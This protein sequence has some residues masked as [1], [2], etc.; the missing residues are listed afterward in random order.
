MK[1]FKLFLLI[2]VGLVIL[3][4]VKPDIIGYVGPSRS[5]I[6]NIQISEF[7]QVLKAFAADTGRFPTSSEGLDALLNDPCNLKGWHGPYLKKDIPQDPWGR[8]YGYCCPGI[9]NPAHY[10]LWSN[11]PDGIEGTGDDVVNYK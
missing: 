2:F 10:D 4:I 11:G 8:A 3:I 6:A 7:E 5:H 9:G 1:I